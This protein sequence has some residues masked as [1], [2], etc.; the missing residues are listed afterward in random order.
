[1]LSTEEGIVMDFRAEQVSKAS[2]PMIWSFEPSSNVTEF[3]LVQYL[4]A[5]FLILVTELGIVTDSK[6]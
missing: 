1:M 5:S 6:L 3:S 4:N 2:S